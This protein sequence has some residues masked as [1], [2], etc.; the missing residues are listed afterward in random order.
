MIYLNICIIKCNLD[1]YSVSIDNTDFNT[2]STNIDYSEFIEE[3]LTDDTLGE[4]LRN[5]RFKLG[6]SISDVANLCNCY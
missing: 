5:P 1:K 4:R 3:K 2:K 6:L